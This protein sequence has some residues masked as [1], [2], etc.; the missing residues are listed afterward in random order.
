MVALYST[1]L[2][3]TRQNKQSYKLSRA[4]GKERKQTYNI[5]YVASQPVTEYLFPCTAYGKL[6]AKH[7]F[8]QIRF[9]LFVPG[10]DI[11]HNHHC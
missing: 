1:A 10:N 9:N 11:H 8:A 2:L 7:S 3:L 4:I 6:I 5:E